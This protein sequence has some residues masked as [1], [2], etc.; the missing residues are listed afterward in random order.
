MLP[1]HREQ[2]GRRRGGETKKKTTKNKK[3]AQKK[4][5]SASPGEMRQTRRGPQPPPPKKNNVDQ[6]AQTSG[7]SPAK[8]PICVSSRD[9]RP[10]DKGGDSREHLGAAE[11]FC[12]E[13]GGGGGGRYC[14]LPADHPPPTPA[15]PLISVSPPSRAPAL[16]AFPSFLFFL[17]PNGYL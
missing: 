9:R 16:D 8:T 10:A 4:V 5:S 3:N 1:R 7:D 15:S 17:S 13:G 14:S 2:G 11:G 6:S 12:G